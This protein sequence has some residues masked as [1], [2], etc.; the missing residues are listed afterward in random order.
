VNADRVSTTLAISRAAAESAT[1]VAWSQ[2]LQFGEP[3]KAP[4]P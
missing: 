4:E 3:R 1:H 2:Y